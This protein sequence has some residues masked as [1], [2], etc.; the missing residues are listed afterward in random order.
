MARVGN[1]LFNYDQGGYITSLIII[2]QYTTNKFEFD[3][4]VSEI[5]NT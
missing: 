5:R 1:V 4:P 3:L 2:D